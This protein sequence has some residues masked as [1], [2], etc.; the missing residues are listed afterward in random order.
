[1][2]KILQ[3]IRESCKKFNYEMIRSTFEDLIRSGN[4]EGALGVAEYNC[5]KNGWTLTRDDMD[6]LREIQ[7]RQETMLKGLEVYV[8]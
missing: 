5:K 6:R 1:M 3:K 4:Y 7:D 2:A 8:R